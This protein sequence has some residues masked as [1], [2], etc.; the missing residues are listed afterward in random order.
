MR[1]GWF[2][3]GKGG[4]KELIT[5]E[6]HTVQAQY[7]LK[8]RRTRGKHDH[9]SNIQN[10]RRPREQRFD[11]RFRPLPLLNNIPNHPAVPLMPFILLPLGLLGAVIQRHGDLQ[12]LRPTQQLAQ[13]ID[14]RKVPVEDRYQLTTTHEHVPGV[15]VLVHEDPGLGVELVEDGVALRL[16][17]LSSPVL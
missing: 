1:R 12:H 10:L 8:I 2:R 16:E 6:E 7:S 3:S 9:A 4:W 5:K 13:R 11:I 14:S 17:Q 15:E